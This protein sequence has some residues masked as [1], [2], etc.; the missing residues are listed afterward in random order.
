MSFIVSARKYRPQSFEDVIGQRHVSATLESAIKTDQ[1]AHAFLFC[2]PRGVGKT[3]CARILAKLINCENPIDKVQPCNAC[4]SCKSFNENAS[5]NIIEL[6]AASNNSVDHIRT[7]I[8]QV[9]FQPQHGNFKVFIIDEVHMLSASAFNAFLKTLEE[10]PPYA[11]FILATTEKHKIIPT[12]L[13]RCQIFDFK[14]IQIDDIVKQLKSIVESEGRTADNEALHIIAQKADGAM[15]DALS[16]YDRIATTSEGNISY[17]DVISNL[18]IL[19]FEYYFKML[20]SILMEDISSVLLQY[21]EICRNGFDGDIFINGFSD[22]LRNLLVC[23]DPV[24]LQL[25]E[26]SESLQNRYKDQAAQVSSSNL[27]TALNIANQCDIHYGKA[28]NKRLHVE[29]ALS[30]MVFM[31]KV[32]ATEQLLPSSH[33]KA[34]ITSPSSK[35]NPVLSNQNKDSDTENQ[36]EKKTESVAE[37]KTSTSIPRLPQDLDLSSLESEQKEEAE[38]LIENI[39]EEEYEAESIM[40]TIATISNKGQQVSEKEVIELADEISPPKEIIQKGNSDVLNTPTLS[41]LESLAAQIQEQDQLIEAKPNSIDI[42]AVAKLWNTYFEGV[43]APTVRTVLKESEYECT[44]SG[45]K[46]YVAS[47]ISKDI[48]SQEDKLFES[49]REHFNIPEIIFDIEVDRERFPHKEEVKPIKLFTKKEKFDK[50]KE[51]NPLIVD[52][53]DRLGLKID[54][55]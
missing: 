54:N 43:D 8:E 53:K 17:K 16:I 28:V 5:F 40:D 19:D 22:H 47:K 29:I 2:G 14:R 55:D 21:D 32:I 30:K 20:D 46:I 3:T 4:S 42:E 15:R 7:L 50:M 48:L 39:S 24:T 49:I 35:P 6:D 44:D 27:M 34:T 11:V 23:K 45:L 41:S 13:S 38:E 25:L 36:A 18:N 33:T 9:R 37:I 31:N 52:M 12:I 1:L 51:V 10:P 26:A